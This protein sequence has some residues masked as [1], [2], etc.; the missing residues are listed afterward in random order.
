MADVG[1]GGGF[2]GLIGDEHGLRRV[3]QRVDDDVDPIGLAEESPIQEQVAVGA[4]ASPRWHQRWYR[5]F[6]RYSGGTW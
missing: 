6:A 5:S 3:L 4:D 1:V 2:P